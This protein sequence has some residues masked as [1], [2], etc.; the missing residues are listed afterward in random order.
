MLNIVK[1]AFKKTTLKHREN[2][3]TNLTK[4]INSLKEQINNLSSNVETLKDNAKKT[5]FLSNEYLLDSMYAMNTKKPRILICGYYGARNLGDELMLQSI[6]KN[7]DKTKFDITILLAPYSGTDP[8]IYAPY[9]IIHYPTKNDDILLLAKNY[10]YIIWGGG[11]VLDDAYYDFNY[12]NISLGYILLKTSIAAFKYGKKV[13]VLGVS[14][15]ETLNDQRFITD[16]KTV[17]QKS[18]FFS[19]RDTNSLKT[20][21]KASLPTDKVRIIDDLVISS[22][23]EFSSKRNTNYFT[24]GLSFLFTDENFPKIKKFIE[25]A[26]NK[27]S[28]TFPDK[29]INLK[30]IPFYDKDNSDLHY[31]EKLMSSIELNQKTKII[32]TPYPNNIEGLFNIYSDCNC[33]ISMRY[34]AILIS[35]LC[36]IKTLSINYGKEHRHYTNKLAYIKERS[37]ELTEISFTMIDDAESTDAAIKKLLNQKT[38]KVNPK[39]IKTAKRKL[40]AILS[41]IK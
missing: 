28:K 41:E 15:N 34:H 4:E 11:A 22:L 24:I 3:Y 18:N 37:T 39:T 9:H 40:D 20:L 14:T 8:S 13:Y 12:Q 35:S 10:D 7:L 33:I 26:T 16:L 19:L 6:L 25:N 36:G 38:N 32:I 30:L 1:R 23:P 5:A 29:I 17:I 31:F 2:S 27:F 21:E